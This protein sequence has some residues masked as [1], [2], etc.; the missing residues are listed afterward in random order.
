MSL[1]FC[2]DL[3]PDA[4]SLIRQSSPQ[5]PI[6]ILYTAQS[7]TAE[8]FVRDFARIKEARLLT[9]CLGNSSDIEDE[10]NVKHLMKTA[11]AE[12]ARR[13]SKFEVLCGLCVALEL[14]S[15]DFC[16]C[17]CENGCNFCIL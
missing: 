8:R 1:R 7:E 9:T 3:R 2:C 17:S 16:Q 5:T 14:L 10:A 12:V 13:S 15:D 6:L 4:S 11:A